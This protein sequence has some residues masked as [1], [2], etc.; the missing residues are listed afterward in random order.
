MFA[1]L[2]TST[3]TVRHVQS[4]GTVASLAARL[5][6]ALSV[7]SQRQKLAALDDAALADIGLTRYEAQAEANRPLWDV[8]A[9]W[10][11]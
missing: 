10:R 1:S 11:N 6:Q 2:H 7:Y 4:R 5:A 3:L 8:P 9:F